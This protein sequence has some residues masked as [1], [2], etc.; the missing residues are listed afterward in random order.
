M[1]GSEAPPVL[2]IGD[3]IIGLVRAIA[4]ISAA[5]LGSYAIVGGVAVA[6]GPDCSVLQFSHFAHPPR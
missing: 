6:G 3:A 5:D 1:S 4:E 2:I